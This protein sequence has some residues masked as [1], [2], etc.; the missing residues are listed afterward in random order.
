MNVYLYPHISNFIR[1]ATFP[2]KG[3]F[4]RYDTLPYKG[5]FLD[6]VHWKN[7]NKSNSFISVSASGF[8]LF[9]QIQFNNNNW[10]RIPIYSLC[11][12]P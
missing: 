9:S 6:M 8:L 12:S 1:C 4:I 5:N 2:H 11:K 7:S 3:N 10:Y